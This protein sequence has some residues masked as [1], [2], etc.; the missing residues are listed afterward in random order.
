MRT[1][2]VEN[3]MSS[4]FVKAACLT[5]YILL[6]LGLSPQAFAAD[7]DDE[8]IEEV[9][10]TG[11][12]LTRTVIGTSTAFGAPEA[13]IGAGPLRRN[14]PNAVNSASESEIGP[15]S[16]PT[17]TPPEVGRVSATQQTVVF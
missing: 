14:T 17:E 3:P 2:L 7:A 6:S 16:I 8:V 9:I 10:V 15:W 12:Y 1:S 4:A 13:T 11:S 5:G